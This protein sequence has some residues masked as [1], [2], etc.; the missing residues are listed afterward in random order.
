MTLDQWAAMTQ[1][2]RC[3]WVGVRGTT[4]ACPRCG[5]LYGRYY[6]ADRERPKEN[7]HA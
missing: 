3:R 5:H 4:G 7:T 2:Q 1:C 6:F